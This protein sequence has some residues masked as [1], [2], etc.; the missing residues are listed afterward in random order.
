[1]YTRQSDCDPGRFQP[2]ENYG[3]S[4]VDR[5]P[6]P[7]EPDR[8]DCGGGYP[9]PPP[10]PPCQPKPPGRGI[11]GGIFDNFEL[12]DLLLIGILLILLNDRD[13]CGGSNDLLPLLAIMLLFGSGR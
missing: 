5:E 7:P 1:M 13:D 11:L 12:D 3:G 2:P 4:L 6:C 9:P 10:E 8:N